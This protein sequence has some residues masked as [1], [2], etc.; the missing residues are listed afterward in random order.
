VSD[1]QAQKDSFSIRRSALQYRVP[2]TTTVSGARAVVNAIEMLL[3][4]E[5][6]IK[7]IQEYH[8]S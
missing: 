4:K 6:S 7:S 5:M 3:K 2:Y 8:K 1:A